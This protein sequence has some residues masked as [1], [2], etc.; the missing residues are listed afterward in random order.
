MKLTETDRERISDSALKIQAVR[1]SISHIDTAKIPK[2]KID[3]CLA[4]VDQS[5]REALGYK[6][7]GD[8]GKNYNSGR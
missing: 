2:R 1:A 8:S 3:D 5:F 6:P 7:P 4:S